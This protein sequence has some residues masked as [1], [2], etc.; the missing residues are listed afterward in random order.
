MK[1]Q[2]LIFLALALAII[3]I[4]IIIAISQELPSGFWGNAYIDGNPAPVGAVVSAFIDSVKCGEYT[5]ETEGIYGVVV[6]PATT[7]PG[8]GTEGAV[9]VFKIN[10]NTATPTGIWHSGTNQYLD[11][12]YSGAPPMTCSL[13]AGCGNCTD[14]VTAAKPHVACSSPFN[15]CVRNSG[16]SYYDWQCCGGM[17]SEIQIE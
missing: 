13:G 10:G 8:C 14:W 11:I 4:Y 15:G 6:A 16:G 17:I 7:H 5:I 9:V 1:K 3:T 2:N 12:S